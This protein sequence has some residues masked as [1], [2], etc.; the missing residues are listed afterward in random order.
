M[1]GVYHPSIHEHFVCLIEARALNA[2]RREDG[3]GGCWRPA[4][5]MLPHSTTR[6]PHKLSAN[7][8]AVV[9]DVATTGAPF[10]Y[11]AC[12]AC[13]RGAKAGV[14]CCAGAAV[15]PR[16]RITLIVLMLCGTLHARTTAKRGT[17]PAG[18]VANPT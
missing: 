3:R 13:Y 2:P 10:T 14:R 17:V 11:S 7:T 9:L 4:L 1:L 18:P 16:W 15:A 12:S 8:A 6:T 5:P